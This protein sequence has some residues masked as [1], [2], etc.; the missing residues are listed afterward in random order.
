MSRLNRF[1][2]MAMFAVLTMALSAPVFA[3]G[4]GGGRGGQR[5]QGGQRDQGGQRGAE[6]YKAALAVTDAEWAVINPLLTKVTETQRGTN[7]RT[8][9]MGGMGGMGGRGGRG[10]AGGG[11]GGRQMTPPTDPV[12]KAQ[13]E[14]TTALGNPATTPAVIKT[15]LDALR[16][17]RKKAEDDHAKACE[18]LIKV[19]KPRQEAQL[20]SMGLIK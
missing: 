14:L 16:A 10:G 17:A 2:L 6:R 18:N 15:K 3:Q 7:P 19:L 8:M 12:G 1:G 4:G 13:A 5:G 9:R 20:V 11:A